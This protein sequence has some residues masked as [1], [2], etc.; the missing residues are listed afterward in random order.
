MRVRLLGRTVLLPGEIPAL[1]KSLV[2]VKACPS[3]YKLMPSATK[4]SSFLL[5]KTECPAKS[6]QT[7]YCDVVVDIRTSRDISCPLTETRLMIYGLNG[8]FHTTR[9]VNSTATAQHRHGVVGN[10]ILWLASHYNDCR[11]SCVVYQILWEEEYMSH[12]TL[13]RHMSWSCTRLTA[14]VQVSREPRHPST[15][16]DC[17]CRSND[18]RAPRSTETVHTTPTRQSSVCCYRSCLS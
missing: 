1:E 11:E 18:L 15:R 8:R 7:G 4:A 9:H 13:S 10:V 5:A 2:I 16:A 14:V 6:Q 3:L 12:F 17:R